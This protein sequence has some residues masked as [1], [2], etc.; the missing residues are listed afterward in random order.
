MRGEICALFYR[1][2]SL[3]GFDYVADVL[4]GPNGERPLPEYWGAVGH[5]SIATEACKVIQD[6]NLKELMSAN[7]DVEGRPLQARGDELAWAC[8]SLRGYGPESSSRNCR[9]GLRCSRYA[10]GSL[11][12]DVNCFSG[13]SGIW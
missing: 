8:K 10:K 2:K 9:R 7:L 12:R 1:F 11:K 5:Y 6:K 4:I 3:A 13:S